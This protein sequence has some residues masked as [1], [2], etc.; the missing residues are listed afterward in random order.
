MQ[1]RTP[2]TLRSQILASARYRACERGAQY[3]RKAPGQRKLPISYKDLIPHFK[4]SLP[5]GVELAHFGAI[6]GSNDWENC[7]VV[8][9]VGK[10]TPREDVVKDIARAIWFDSA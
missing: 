5:V 7:D 6:R 1:S 9:V 2:A 8:F 3:A 10:N 4:A